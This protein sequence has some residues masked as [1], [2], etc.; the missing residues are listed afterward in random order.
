MSCGES[1][2]EGETNCDGDKDL[3]AVVGNRGGGTH[4]KP[5][6][7]SRADFIFEVVHLPT[8]FCIPGRTLFLHVF[9]TAVED[10]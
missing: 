10:L 3:G 6:R 2:L 5:S 8:G 4:K 7:Q 9:G 1:Q